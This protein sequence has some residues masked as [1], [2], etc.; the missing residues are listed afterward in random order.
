MQK[1]ILNVLK[2][3]FRTFGGDKVTPNN[4]MSIALKDNPLQFAGAV[5]VLDV[6]NC[7]LETSGYNNLLTASIRLVA[8]MT[9][10]KVDNCE[11][12]KDIEVE[13]YGE[14]EETVLEIIKRRNEEQM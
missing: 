1:V 2:K 3:C 11:P 12:Y 4:I 8:G 14:L 13:A 5:D 7:V 10:K 9:E 6:V